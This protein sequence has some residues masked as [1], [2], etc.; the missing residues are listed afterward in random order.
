MPGKGA[1]RP[2]KHDLI[3]WNG[4]RYTWTPKGF[5]RCTSFYDRHNLTHRIWLTVHG[6]PVPAGHQ[7][8]FADGNRFNIAPENLL[9][10]TRRE[11]QLRILADP[12]KLAINTA[13]LAYGHLVNGI[14]EANDPER[15]AQ[16][17]QKVVATRRA[18]GN[19][20]TGTE[21][22]RK[23]KLERYG[24]KGYSGVMKYDPQR[25]HDAALKAWETRRSTAG[26]TDR[27]EG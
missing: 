27:I 17:F 24:P 8:V 3:E 6:E 2:V 10:L 5:W 23:T 16:R 1:G 25:R 13:Y 12:T 26:T 19:Y 21:K 7:I 20:T 18:K 11:V 9:C 15:K 22:A 14:L 4:N